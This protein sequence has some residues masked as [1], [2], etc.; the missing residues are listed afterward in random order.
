MNWTT[1]LENQLIELRKIK[2]FT[3]N[4]LAQKFNTT[5]SSIKHKLR[6]IGQAQN[7][8]Q[9]THPVEKIGQI[10]NILPVKRLT[11]LETH[12]G[13]GN[14]TKHY[15]SLGH[16]VYAI[17]IDP[18]KF[19]TLK[20]L[21]LNDVDLVLADSLK[22]LLF[23]EYQEVWFDVVDLDPYGFPSRFV[24]GALRLI[25]NGYLFMTMPKIGVSQ[26]NKITIRHLKEFWGIEISSKPDLI[27]VVIKKMESLAFQ[28]Y[29]SSILLDVID[30]G[31]MFRFVFK[32]EKTSMAKLVDLEIQRKP[33]ITKYS[34]DYLPLFDD[35][36]ET[37]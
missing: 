25:N 24:P 15:Q 13:Q 30:L 2:R 19:E 35:V 14:L 28:N 32:I 17:E 4:Q 37:H 9:Y 31:R 7:E 34:N 26:M 3:I 8:N 36:E 16:E 23:L 1:E 12:A 11:I 10:N 33:I 27:N 20:Q 18:I 22:H 29:R 5:P 21:H 6:R